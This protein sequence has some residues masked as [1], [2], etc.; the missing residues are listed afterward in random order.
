MI[1]SLSFGRTLT[2]LLLV[3]AALLLSVIGRSTLSR[4]DEGQIAEVSREMVEFG[5]W[6][7]PRIGGTPFGPYPPLA[8]WLFAASGAAFGF[9]EFAMRLPT[10]LASLGLVAVLANL[11]RRKAGP[12]A[13]IA[14]GGI[15][16]TLPCFFIQSGV[17]RADV[18]TTFLAVAAFDRFLAW[19]EG[20]KRPRDL[21]LMYLFTSLGILA[22]GP[23]AIALLGLA[24]LAWF[25]IH[26]QWKLLLAMKFW[27]GIP[28][29]ILI[30][31]PWYWAVTRLHGWDFL[32]ENLFMENL[33]AFG[34]G[35]VQKRPWYFYFKQIPLLL[36]WAFLL[37]LAGKVR[38]A[39]GVAFSLA[40]LGLVALFFTISASKRINYLAYFCPAA[41]MAAGTTLAAL[42]S[43][44]PRLV[45]TGL[46]GFCAIMAAGA[47]AI[48]LLPSSIWTG[49]GVLKIAPRF[50]AIGAALGAAAVAIGV[51]A[52][53]RGP[54]AGSVGLSAV[55]AAGFFVYGFFVNPGMNEEYR[56]TAEFSRRAAALAPAGERIHTLHPEG[57]QGIVH[58]YAGAA[59]TKRQ[60]E[61]GLYVVE[62]PQHERLVREGKK[63]Q[64]LDSMLDQR[65][66]FRYLLRV[67]P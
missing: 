16:A 39:P 11:V 48:A 33:H 47:I 66:R 6:V 15:L 40:W 32:H 21:A 49:G 35:Y 7:T 18:L 62:Q 46:L 4:I 1:G 22:K 5:D 44:A 57:V 9:N 34:E 51:L 54:E 42:R 36:P 41:A 27:I 8:Y 14:S 64:V 2:I 19:A 63:L 67:L 65:G 28:A 50:P 20:A 10:A 26:R 52:W 59:L 13:G 29:A 25:L 55:L 31:V 37:P 17:C 58:F 12:E 53:R 43:D 30:V 38:K 3:D 23:I 60:G 45:R 56:R 61:P 24:G